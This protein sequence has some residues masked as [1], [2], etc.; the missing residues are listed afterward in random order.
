MKSTLLT[1]IFV[2][3]SMQCMSQIKESEFVKTQVSFNYDSTNAIIGLLK[4]NN[5]NTIFSFLQ[6]IIQRQVGNHNE[7]GYVSH[8]LT[9]SGG[10]FNRIAAGENTAAIVVY[11][12]MDTA[13]F[14]PPGA[15]GPTLNYTADFESL[16]SI[17]YQKRTILKGT[18]RKNR[19]DTIWS[20]YLLD[21][22]DIILIYVDYEDGYYRQNNEEHKKLSNSEIKIVYHTSFFKNSFKDLKTVITGSM[23]GGGSSAVPSI[24]ITIVQLNKRAIKSPC[25][26]VIQNKSF[27]KNLEFEIHE[28]NF[29]SFQ[30]GVINNKYRANNFS[31]SEGNLV[32]KPDDTQKEEWKSNLF[33]AIEFHPIGYGP[34]WG[35]DIDNFNPIWK[36]LFAI[37]RDIRE[38]GRG[39][40]WFK[41]IAL[42]RIGI[43]GGLRISKD[44]LSSLH[45][46]FNYAIT[47][48]LYLNFGWVWNNELTPQV[49]AIGDIS[50]LDDAAKYARRKYSGG[51]FSWGLSFAPSSIIDMLGIKG[52]E[53]D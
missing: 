49:T 53:K 43:Y 20:D 51:K 52:K 7:L 26:I 42:S 47:K 5:K 37:K 29:A 27:K 35:R 50:S 38:N 36:D 32:V 17:I 45:A 14:T 8:Y 6:T 2:A 39:W 16:N 48:E 19:T 18:S 3:L 30:V 46:G 25:D 4:A 44:P 10:L 31:I 34:A 21:T 41:D 24:K 13:R 12:D 9:D 40:K 15:S 23:S 28:R 11:R 33:A 1:A 22:R